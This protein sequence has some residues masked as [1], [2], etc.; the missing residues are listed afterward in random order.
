M[1]T[2]GL[3][4]RVQYQLDAIPDTGERPIQSVRLFAISDSY[5][6]RSATVIERLP[7]LTSGRTTG[8]IYNAISQLQAP[9]AFTASA[10]S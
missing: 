3:D 5:V 1:N 10:P 4:N 6:S 2:N 8:N 7:S 9:K